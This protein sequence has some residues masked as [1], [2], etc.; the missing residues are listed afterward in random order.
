MLSENL[1]KNMNR[2]KWMGTMKEN[3]VFFPIFD[4]VL[5]ANKKY[6]LHLYETYATIIIYNF[7]IYNPLKIHYTQIQFH[8]FLFNKIIN[9]IV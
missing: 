3:V 7:Y 4:I 8:V 2:V 1:L 5:K 6:W 9:K